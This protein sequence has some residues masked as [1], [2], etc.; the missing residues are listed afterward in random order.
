MQV[1]AP[2]G[3]ELTV[4]GNPWPFMNPWSYIVWAYGE[5]GGT[6]FNIT[7]AGSTE[8]IAKQT[9]EWADLKVR[10][11]SWN[12]ARIQSHEDKVHGGTTLLWIGPHNE[13][14]TFVS[15]TGVPLELFMD[16][17]AKFDLRD[18]PEGVTMLPRAGSGLRLTN[19]LATNAIDQLCSVQIKPVADAHGLIPATKGKGVTGG[20]MWRF[21][22][23]DK[24]GDVRV[25]SAFVVNN[26]TAT[27][28]V[29][30]RPTDPKFISVVESLTCSLSG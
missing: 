8:L 30:N 6:R 9:G 14:G 4:K 24:A 15:G 11:I 19:L 27:T 20:A 13:I 29:A 22:E 23:L 5:G 1:R 10:E 28:V 7:P 26:S 18:A 16:T 17:L 21:D 2:D 25:R 3:R 12:G